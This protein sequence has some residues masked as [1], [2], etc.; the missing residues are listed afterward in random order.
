MSQ[1]YGDP[2]TDKMQKLRREMGFLEKGMQRVR[3]RLDTI[4]EDP[5]L[6]H[7]TSLTGIKPKQL[8][9]PE[10]NGYPK[11]DHYWELMIHENA[12]YPEQNDL[13]EK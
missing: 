5:L 4:Q 3:M 2:K 7:T 1:L 9:G 6:T 11:Y 8:I 13:I 10:Y 12:I